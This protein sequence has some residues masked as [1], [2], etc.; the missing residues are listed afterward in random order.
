MFKIPQLF[1]VQDFKR[2]ITDAEINICSQLECTFRY[3][4]CDPEIYELCELFMRDLQL[5][6]PEDTASARHLY[7]TLRDC[8]NSSVTNV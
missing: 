2:V 3:C 4:P 8:I 5:T 1:G 7:V 6:M